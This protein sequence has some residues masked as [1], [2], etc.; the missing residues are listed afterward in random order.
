MSKKK[1]YRE[2]FI[3]F[4]NGKKLTYLGIAE[5][6]EDAWDSGIADIKISTPFVPEDSV[7]QMI[8]QRR[9]ELMER[10]GMVEEG[11]EGSVDNPA[12]P[13]SE[14]TDFFDGI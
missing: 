9:R 7:T 6:D 12:P 13:S 11:K 8:E 1:E 2:V 3:T 5:N 4:N 10:L 14:D